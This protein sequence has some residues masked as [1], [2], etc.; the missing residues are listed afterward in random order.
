MKKHLL[1]VTAL[2]SLVGC[3]SAVQQIETPPEASK[4]NR[5]N[6]DLTLAWE[7][8]DLGG[9]AYR[10]AGYVHVLHEDALWAPGSNA[11]GSGSASGTNQ[12]MPKEAAAPS[13]AESLAVFKSI[14]DSDD[15]QTNKS[16]SFYELSRWERFC[17]A[18]KGMDEKDW[19]F[20]REEGLDNIPSDALAKCVPPG[21]GYQEY[22]RA[23]ESFCTGKTISEPQRH[24][25]KTSVRPTS[26]VNPCNA[27]K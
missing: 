22:L 17:E 5:V 12:T 8:S 19:L 4:T 27:L 20:V 15:K 26:V 18:G 21:Y 14:Q 2:A 3:T 25:I 7:T 10:Q 11:S 24:I 6:R 23:W 16:Y 9:A 1:A 13:V